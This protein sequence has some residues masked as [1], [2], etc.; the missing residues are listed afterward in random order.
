MKDQL[1]FAVI[2]HLGDL[3]KVAM[4][5]W[6]LNVAENKKTPMSHRLDYKEF[7]NAIFHSDKWQLE[8][9][10]NIWRYYS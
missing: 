1:K 4:S 6:N 7:E 2:S 9:P 8:C 3:N 10:L 5:L